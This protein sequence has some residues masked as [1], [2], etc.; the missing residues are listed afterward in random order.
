MTKVREDELGQNTVTN[1]PDLWRFPAL[2]QSS[3]WSP[4]WI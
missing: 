4:A 1:I 2:L 3:P